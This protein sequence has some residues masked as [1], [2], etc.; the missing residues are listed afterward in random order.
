LKNIHGFVEAKTTNNSKIILSFKRLEKI[1][2]F[3]FVAK[4]DI[5]YGCDAAIFLCVT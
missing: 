1:L 5:Y 4:I 2:F 3:A